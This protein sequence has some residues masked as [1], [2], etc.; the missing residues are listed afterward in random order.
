MAD[1]NTKYK[2]RD[3]GKTFMG[4]A[5]TRKD[6]NGTPICPHCGKEPANIERVA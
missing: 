4:W 3:C 5:S 2:C 1:N 6:R